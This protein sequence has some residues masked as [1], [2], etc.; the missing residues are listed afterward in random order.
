MFCSTSTC[1]VNIC[2]G[3]DVLKT[4]SS[5]S[6]DVILI[7]TNILT[8]LIHLQMTSSRHLHDVWIKKNLFVLA[9][10]DVLNNIFKTSCKNV[11]KMSSRHLRNVFPG[12]LQDFFKTSSRRL[13]KI[14]S[15]L[16][17]SSRHLEEVFK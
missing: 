3:D 13:A 5:L 16:K 7:K 10:Q 11:L 17:I 15:R 4:F 12:R 2:I 14:S 6:S 8:L 1:L 9:I